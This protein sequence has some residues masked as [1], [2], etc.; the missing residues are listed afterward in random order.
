MV[1]ARVHGAN[2]ANSGEMAELWVIDS[3]LVS[4]RREVAFLGG[5][6]SILWYRH[7]S[8]APTERILVKW[9]NSRRRAAISCQGGF[10]Q[11][12][13]WVEGRIC[14]SGMSGSVSRWRYGESPNSG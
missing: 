13:S 5:G 1:S 10:K 14:G 9:P 7:G 2:R 4:R 12:F 6:G 8:V 3:D 11:R